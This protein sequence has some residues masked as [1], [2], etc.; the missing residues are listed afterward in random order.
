[1]GSG[2]VGVRVELLLSKVVFW[3]LEPHVAHTKFPNFYPLSYDQ[4]NP[5]VR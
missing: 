4:N 3:A 1:M 5:F 2:G